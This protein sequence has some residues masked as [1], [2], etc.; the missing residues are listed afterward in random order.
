MG[1]VGYGALDGIDYYM[2][3]VAGK[4]GTALD[5]KVMQQYVEVALHT[6][7]ILVP[8]LLVSSLLPVGLVVLARWTRPSRR[9]SV[10]ARFVDANWNG[11]HRSNSAVSGRLG[12][13]RPRL[14]RQ[15]RVRR[16]EIAESSE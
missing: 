9:P 12:P 4:P 11:W 5:T 7:G 16:F 10:L 15:L 14:A 13:L 2:N 3:W 8:V 6:A 1:F